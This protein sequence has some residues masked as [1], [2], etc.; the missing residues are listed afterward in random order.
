MEKKKYYL[1]CCLVAKTKLVGRLTIRDLVVP[2]PVPDCSEGA[3][4]NKTAG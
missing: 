4:V 1:V 2:E 3:L